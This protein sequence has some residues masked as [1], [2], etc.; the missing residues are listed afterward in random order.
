MNSGIISYSAV[1]LAMTERNIVTSNLEC[2]A[3]LSTIHILI[4]KFGREKWLLK[5]R[6]AV[7][8][9][10]ICINEDQSSTDDY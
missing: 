6:E 9:G 8:L 4:Y 10:N 5:Y 2:Q 1:P 3:S 7:V